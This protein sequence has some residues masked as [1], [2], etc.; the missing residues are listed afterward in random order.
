MNN[1]E[2]SKCVYLDG[3]DVAEPIDKDV[4]R[5]AGA[6]ERKRYA[7]TSRPIGV[8]TEVSKKMS[9]EAGAGA[10]TETGGPT[11]AAVAH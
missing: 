10:S 7:N 11:D 5:D 6:G 8:P 3:E 4:A 2:P 1:K 9:K